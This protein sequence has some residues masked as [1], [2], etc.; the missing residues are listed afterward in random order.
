MYSTT[1]DFLELFALKD[2][3]NLPDLEE[4]RELEG[5]REPAEPPETAFCPESPDGISQP[6]GDPDPPG[7]IPADAGRQRPLEPAAEVLGEPGADR[8]PPDSGLQT[9]PAGSSGSKNEG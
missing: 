9:N 8:P 6:D 3:E 5:L 4:F 2:L 1:P 7:R